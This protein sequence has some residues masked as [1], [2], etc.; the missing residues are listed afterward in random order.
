MKLQVEPLHYYDIEYDSK[1][2]SERFSLLD[3][4]RVIAIVLVLIAHIGQAVGNPIGEFF[5]VENFYWVSVGGVGVTLF[6]ILSGLAL[7][8]NY[9]WAN[10]QNLYGVLAVSILGHCIL[11]S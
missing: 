11:C 7:E 6:L 9:G 8:L 5:G 10:T 2:H 4:A 1:G 3:L